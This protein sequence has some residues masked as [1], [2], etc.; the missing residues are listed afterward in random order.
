MDNIAHTLVGAALGR[1]VAGGRVPYASLVGAVAANAPDWTELLIGLPADTPTYLVLHRGITHSLVGAAAQ[2]VGLGAL[3]WAGASWFVRRR[4]GDPPSVS[5]V[6]G[7]LAATILSHL[8][9]DWQGSYGL[10]PFLPWSERWYYGDFVAIVD[11]FFWLV[12]LVAL[13]W[14]AHRHWRPAAGFGGSLVVLLGVV[15]ANDAV[16]AWAK[17]LCAGLAAVAAVGWNAH[18][19]GA[20]DGGRRWA[21]VWGLAALAGY[22]ALQAAAS[23]PA[24]AQVRR[25][26]RARFGPGAEWAALTV[27]GQPFSWQA[28]YASPDSVAG[29][30]WRLGRSLDRPIVREV[31]RATPE[32]RA[33]AQFARFLIADVDSAETGVT[34]YLRDARYRREGRDGWGVLAV[35]W[36]TA[37]PT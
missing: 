4:G 5:L 20:A 27:V 28:M 10:R 37:P 15:L 21:A 22:A 16:A 2:I 23:V 7:C 36:R 9:M 18:W 11:V 35:R 34:V 8:Y 17:A 14:G 32:G 31:L 33:M 25:A 3:V 1:A 30:G 19:F 29:R 6:L 24:K 26:A 12:P 13:A